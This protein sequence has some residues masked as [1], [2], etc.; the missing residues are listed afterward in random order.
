MKIAIHQGYRFRDKNGLVGCVL[1]V[2]RR[3]SRAIVAWEQ[4][5]GEEPFDV[6]KIDRILASARLAPDTLRMNRM[7]CLCCGR[8]RQMTVRAAARLAKRLGVKP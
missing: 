4:P 1:T 3:T 5:G 6:L 8:G 2:G 7:P